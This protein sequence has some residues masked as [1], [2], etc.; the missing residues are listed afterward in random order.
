MDGIP[1]MKV[2]LKFEKR[3]DEI[4]EPLGT[5]VGRSIN[6]YLWKLWAGAIT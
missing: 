3:S 6:S 4:S 5:D 2:P 1:E